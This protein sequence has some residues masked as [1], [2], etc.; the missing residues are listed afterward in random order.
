MKCENPFK[1]HEYLKY[2]GYSIQLWPKNFDKAE[3]NSEI[4]DSKLVDIKN[5][6]I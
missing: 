6:P 2:F 3:D 1:A 5:G 4:Y